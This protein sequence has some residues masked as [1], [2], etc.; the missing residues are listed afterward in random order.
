MIELAIGWFLYYTE[1]P[2][3]LKFIYW[4]MLTGLIMSKI[5]IAYQADK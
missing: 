3:I 1:A 5:N 2:L 4:F